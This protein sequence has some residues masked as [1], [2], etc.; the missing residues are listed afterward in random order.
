M[1]YLFC[2]R[3]GKKGVSKA[4]VGHQ[5][6][7]IGKESSPSYKKVCKYCKTQYSLE[8]KGK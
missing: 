7:G 5:Y 4:M 3:C 2:R 8:Y 6:L 1:A